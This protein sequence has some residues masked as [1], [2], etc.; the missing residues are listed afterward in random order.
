MH[1]AGERARMRRIGRELEDIAAGELTP[2]YVE[3]GT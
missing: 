1:K 2:G 3:S